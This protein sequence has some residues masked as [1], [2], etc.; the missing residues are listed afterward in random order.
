ML[1]PKKSGFQATEVLVIRKSRRKNE[2]YW[3]R[4][5]LSKCLMH[6]GNK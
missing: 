2:S 6:G 5:A 3:R 4:A 1:A